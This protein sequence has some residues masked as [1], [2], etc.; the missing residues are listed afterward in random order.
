MEKLSTDT[1]RLSLLEYFYEWEELKPNHIFLRQPEGNKWKDLS[2]RE[3]GN[4]ARKIAAALLDMGLVPGEN[5][6]IL[7]KNC[8]H[9]IITDLAIM[10]SGLISVPFYPNQTADQLAE[11][12]EAGKIKL[13]FVGKLEDWENQQKGVPANLPIISFPEYKGNS[14]VTQGMKWDILINRYQPLIGNPVP[15]LQDIWTILFT[16]GTTGK[17]KGVM[18]DFDGPAALMQLEKETNFLGLSNTKN[19][20]FFSYLPLNHIAE[21]LIVA[22]AAIHTGGSIS[23]G[24]SIQTFITNLKQTQPTVF[25]AVPRIWTKFRMGI[26]AKIPEPLLFNLINIPLLG[27]VLKHLLKKNLGL[28]NAKI[29][30]TGAAP[31]SDSLKFFFNKLG[32]PVQEV[33]AM[34]ENCGG[35]T[36]MPAQIQKKGTVGKAV[37]GV[38]LK[39]DPGNGEILMQAPW[40]MRGYFNDDV[41]T[42][43]VIRD[44]WLHTGDMGHLDEEG[45]LYITGRISETFKSSKGKFIAPAP[46]EWPFAVNDLIE[47]VCVVGLGLPQPL[48]L[49][50]LSEY[51]TSLSKKEINV[52][53]EN[54]LNGVN[55]KVANY[56]KISAVVVIS[57]PWDVSN[58]ILTPTLKIKRDRLNELFSAKYD[59]WSKSDQ[60][61]IWD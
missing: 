20:R 58:G 31:A 1:H 2:W 24:E 54:T 34:T 37:P 35:C 12:I 14:P 17:P 15:D 59:A 44:Q 26:V 10:M 40:L 46:L 28:S 39:I 57:E 23:F 38:S 22:A 32:M 52:S 53:L 6:G 16:S 9:W 30:L 50:N 18:I 5:V 8:C 3:V 42:S 25:M 48:A 11:V 61:V 36:L 41:L 45:Y 33:Y 19:H 7:S 43:E 56:E 47:Q 27:N 29:R 4:Q 55:Q 60:S 21:R 49:I 13:L 51:A